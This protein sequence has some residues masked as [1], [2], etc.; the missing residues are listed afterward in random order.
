MKKV[1]LDELSDK[2][3]E[4]INFSKNTIAQKI[5]ELS[6]APNNFV[7]QGPSSVSYINKYNLLIEKIK[8]YNDGLTK[9]ANFLV[10]AK[11][12]Y[13]EANRKIDSAY[14]ELLADFG[15]GDN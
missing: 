5:I 7:W 2:G 14:D 11:D 15:S 9:I 12:S 6:E 3:D 8:K 1:Y 10:T 13:S 4:L